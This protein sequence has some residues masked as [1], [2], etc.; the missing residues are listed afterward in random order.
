VSINLLTTR[1]PDIIGWSDACPFGTGGYNTAG[2]AW[3][4][5]I[6]PESPIF[7]TSQVNNALEYIAITV[8]AIVLCRDVPGQTSPCVLALGDNTSAIG[9]LYRSSQLHQPHH[10]VHLQIAQHD[11]AHRMIRNDC[12]LYSQHIPGARNVIADLLSYEGKG[13]DKPHPIAH[14]Q[15]DDATLTS[16]F[17]SSPNY[18]SQITSNFRISPLPLDIDSW[19]RRTLQMLESYVSAEL[20][21]PL[22]QPTEHGT[23]GAAT[24]KSSETVGKRATNTHK[25][26]LL[27]YHQVSF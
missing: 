1:R 20:S 26:V 11:L 6:D 8:N 17:Y 7:G 9:W 25:L 2:R 14:D 16:H 13:C 3:R 4:L 19:L 5:L 18:S 15:P 21:S 27:S 23:D 22:S 24:V 12:C 10:A